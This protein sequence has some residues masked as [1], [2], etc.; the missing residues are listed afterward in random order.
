MKKFFASACNLDNQSNMI[1]Y[2]YNSYESENK[3]TYILLS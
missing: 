2:F 3:I 1:W